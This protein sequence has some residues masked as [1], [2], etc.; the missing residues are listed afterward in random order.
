MTAA[1]ELRNA[2]YKV[3]MLEFQD[4]AGGRNGSIHGGDE[5]TELGGEK[6]VCQFDKDQYINPGP[7]RIP[8]H[9]HAVLEYCKRL[10]VK[11]EPFIQM[12]FNAYL[13]SK[14]AFN[15]SPQRYRHV[16][17]DFKGGVTELLS[18]AINSD[19]LDFPLAKKTKRFC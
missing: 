1:L 6:Q 17:S 7:W 9:H 8:Y 12:N 11:L 19:L 5:Y 14:D 18:K 15:G 4:R 2:G 10:N 16:S 3:K 13:H